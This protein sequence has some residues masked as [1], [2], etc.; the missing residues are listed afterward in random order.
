M[1]TLAQG[2]VEST[3]KEAES[4]RKLALLQLLSAHFDGDTSKMASVEGK[5]KRDELRSIFD[6]L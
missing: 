3:E 4:K 5:R 1:E 2:M 6:D